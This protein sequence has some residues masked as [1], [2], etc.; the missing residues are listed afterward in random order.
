MT[1][2]LLIGTV[3]KFRSSCRQIP[4]QL[5]SLLKDAGSGL[6]PYPGVPLTYFAL[7]SN[8]CCV[9]TWKNAM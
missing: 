3:H 7:P 1:V 4:I 8:G 2:R 9:V 6:H 5:G